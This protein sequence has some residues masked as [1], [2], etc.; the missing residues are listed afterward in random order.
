M[1]NGSASVTIPSRKGREPRPDPRPR[2]GNVNKSSH[3]FSR[4]G[5]AFILKNS[6]GNHP[7]R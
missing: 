5:S 3:L 4:H 7:Y 1:Q 2:Q 6:H